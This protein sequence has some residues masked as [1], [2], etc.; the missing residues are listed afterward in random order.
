VLVDQQFLRCITGGLHLDAGIAKL[1]QASVSGPKQEVAAWAPLRVADVLSVTAR[2]SVWAAPAAVG[3]SAGSQRDM[4][5][6]CSMDP[7]AADA[8]LHLG[9]ILSAAGGEPEV[10]EVWVPIAMEVCTPGHKHWNYEHLSGANGH[11]RMPMN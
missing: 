1:Q 2:N 6:G 3:N 8:C 4:A 10:E 5:S 9:A 11:H 7:A